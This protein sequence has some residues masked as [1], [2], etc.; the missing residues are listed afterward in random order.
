MLFLKDK[1][2]PFEPLYGGLRGNVRTPSIARWKA[3][4]R[5]YIRHNT[6]FFSYLLR[7]RH[8][9]RKSF[10]VGVSR[11]QWVNLSA[12]FRRKVYHPPTTVGVR[13]LE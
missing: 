5:L 6:T 9:K 4:D 10:E 3:R 2:S 8:Y 7:F 11:R 12:D 13:K 1:K